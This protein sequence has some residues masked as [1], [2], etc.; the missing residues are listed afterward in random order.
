[1]YGSAV[2]LRRVAALLLAAA[3]VATPAQQSPV[4]ALEEIVVTATKRATPLQNVP[5]AVSALSAEDIVARGFTQYADYLSSLPGVYFSDGGPGVSQIRIR[6]LSA[7][8]GGV[9]PVV[10]SYFGE[11][12]T[13]VRTNF[14]GKP[15]LRMVDIDRVE[16]LRGPQGT[17]FGA[18]AL[19]GVVRIIPAAP[20]LEKMTASAGLRG[21]TT[22]HS[23]DE[24]YHAEAVLNLPLV[25]DRFGVRL[26]AYKD[27]T[28]GFVDN[29]FAGQEEIDYSPVGEI[30]LGQ[31]PGSLPA[32]TLL[33]PA[34]PAFSTRD[35]NSEE[36][37]GARLAATWKV[38]DALSFDLSLARQEVTLNSEPFITPGAG[39]YTQERL[40]DVFEAGEF[41]EEL[42]VS[43]LTARYDW[44]AV[45]LVSVTSRAEMNRP[46]L[47]DIHGLAAG[48]LGVPIPWTLRNDT[49]GEMLTQELRLQSRSEGPFGW[50]FGA[51]YLEEDV[52]FFQIVRDYSCPNC[53]PQFLGQDFALRGGGTFGE[54]QHALFGEV[55]YDFSP[56]W[57]VGV[58]ARWLEE[59][60]YIQFDELEGF[61]APAS[62][63]F[64]AEESVSEFNPS[65]YLQFR[66]VP[67]TTLYLQAAR[68]FRSA[69][70]NQPLPEPCQEEAAAVGLGPISDPDT[71]WNYE[72]GSKST[73]AGGK[74]SANFAVYRSQWD[75]VQL[76]SSLTCGFNGTLNGGDVRAKGVELELL[77]RPTEAWRFNLAASHNDNKFESAQPG[78]G[79]APGERLPGSPK[80]NYSLGAQY[81]FNLGTRWRGFARA[82]YTHVGDVRVVFIGDPDVR[83]DAYDT[84]NARLGFQTDALSVDLY[85]RN[86]TDERAVVSQGE[87][88]L[89]GT[90]VIIRP[91]EIGIELRYRYR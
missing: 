44:R 32:G 2:N 16:V 89:G 71:L 5:V 88:A 10:A 47:R 18:N 40:A 31:P 82:D 36:T 55:T 38:S 45:S 69:Q 83:L 9:P 41:G 6:G 50:I 52:S 30:L 54:E 1:M 60:V 58:G 7:A 13:S 84:A 17:L 63:G 46:D 86:L 53:F 74:L 59:D 90:Q 80:E 24:S 14:G 8:E 3:P 73:F 33:I 27:D 20:N 48:A 81:N 68:G 23:D 72:L 85:A 26:V 51:F 87:P 75:G 77:M 78:T 91:R 43:S 15:N 4:A 22:A 66:P 70:P 25:A 19:A 28:A 64:S 29:V 42:D 67:T 11:S 79:F 76:G 57:T 62:S 61:L 21:F 39:D 34:I 12:L 37:W 49:S 65:A 56:R 35:V